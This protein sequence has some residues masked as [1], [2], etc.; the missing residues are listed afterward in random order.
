MK[1]YQRLWTKPVG[2]WGVIAILVCVIAPQ[3][4]AGAP[5]TDGAQTSSAELATED[6]E[7]ATAIVAGGCF[8]CVETDFE[9]APGV[10]DVISGYSGGRGKNPTYKNYS[11]SGH[12]EV[13]LVVYDPKKITYAGIVEW[14]VKHVD[15][16]D[17]GGQFNDRGKQYAPA[18]YYADDTE[19]AE[20]ERV[21]RAIDELQVYKPKKIQMAVEPRAEFWPAEEYHQDYHHKNR[22]KYSF[23]RLNSGR[24]R[25]V[26]GV[27]GKRASKLELPGSVPP[28]SDSAS[29]D[30]DATSENLMEKWASFKKPSAAELRRKLTKVQYYVTQQDGTERAFSNA[31]NS[32]KKPG[33]YV[34]VVSGAPLFSSS[35]KF[36]SGTGWPSFT[37]PIQPEAI[38]THID[39]QL[40]STRIE[41]R[42]R[43]GDS[44]LGHVF[45]DGPVDK[46][47]KRYCMNSA[48]LRFI[49]KQDM[50]KEGYE[51]FLKFVE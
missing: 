23:F 39:R 38:E 36:E 33:I 8:W 26:S 48:S 34:D 29:A 1:F 15:P 30:E 31:Y 42:S 44:H 10:I 14:L 5:G 2:Y 27:W 17:P 20:A 6:S 3:L 4:I 50:Q 12:R 35:T 11:S 51:D 18:I 16:T 24:D 25:F 46:G 41:V 9:L 32:N 47:G 22:L 13:A 49:P 43:Y 40:F 21:I 37:A 7:Q 28:A 19:K 45:D